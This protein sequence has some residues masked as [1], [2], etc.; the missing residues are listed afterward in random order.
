MD[1]DVARKS[2]RP[3]GFF[4]DFELELDDVFGV[5]FGH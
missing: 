4:F 2:M 3:L 5:G 1:A